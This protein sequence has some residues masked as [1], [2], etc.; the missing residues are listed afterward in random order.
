MA[1]IRIK[2]T[3]SLFWDVTQL[4][5]VVITDV[6]EQPIGAIFKGQEIQE[7]AVPKRR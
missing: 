1:K 5:L 2:M 3:S 7:E 6:S 4:I